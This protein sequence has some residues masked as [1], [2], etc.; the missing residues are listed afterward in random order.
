MDGV[1]FDYTNICNTLK[2]QSNASAI[3]RKVVMLPSLHF[4]TDC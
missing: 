2:T 3:I 1:G 4:P